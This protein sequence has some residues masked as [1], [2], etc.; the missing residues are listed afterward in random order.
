MK[1]LQSWLRSNT[2]RRRATFVTN[3]LTRRASRWVVVS[4]PL[5]T[6]VK[7][8]SENRMSSFLQEHIIHCGQVLEK[9]PHSCSSYVPRKRMNS[10]L[11]TCPKVRSGATNGE[12]KPDLSEYE[13][14]ILILE[15]DISAL[16]SVLNEEIKQ[17]LHLITDVGSLRKHNQVSLTL[18]S[19]QFTIYW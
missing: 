5:F 17:R 19:Q 18:Y 3:G 16:R 2:R 7:C 12:T 10:H 15:Q 6:A 4:V 9:C 1:R 8:S 13:N 14:R 11:K